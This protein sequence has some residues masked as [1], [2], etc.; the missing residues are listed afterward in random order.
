MDKSDLLSIQEFSKYTG[1]KQ[2]V[3]RYYDDIGLFSPIARGSNNYRQYSPQQIITLNMV[4][5]F[6][7][8]RVVLREIGELQRN[9][10]P[11]STLDQLEKQEEILDLEMIRLQE[12]YSIARVYRRLLREGLSAD[13]SVVVEKTLHQTP[14]YIGWENEF[15]EGSYYQ[16]FIKFCQLARAQ[17]VNLSFPVGGKFNSMEV[18]TQRPSQPNF[19]FSLDPSGTAQQEAGRYLVGY[20]QGDYGVTGNVPQM[21]Q[22]YAEEHGLVFSGPV[23]VTY[24]FDEVS[25]I[26]PD[27]YVGRICVQVE[28]KAQH[29]R[30]TVG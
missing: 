13:P 15:E 18:F 3:L 17:G 29:N 28:D 20:V 14:M 4:S 11:K 8:L 30:T 2:S 1:V 21:M 22:A 16:D 23:Y 27:Q 10:T 25:T 12:A 7:D 6:S 9:R 24:V 19:F 5:V 26:D